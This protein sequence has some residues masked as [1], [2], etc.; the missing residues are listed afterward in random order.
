VV[1]SSSELAKQ[2]LK[3][4]DQQL[5]NRRRSRAALKFSRN[6]KDLIWADYGPNYVKVRKVSTLELLSSKKLKA[7]RPIREDE[8]TAMVESIFR[9]CTNPD[10]L[11]NQ[12]LTN[13]YDLKKKG[14]N[15]KLKDY[16]STVSFNNITRLV[17]G[18]RLMSPEGVL[19]EQGLEFKD[20]LG[21]G[22][23][24]WALVT[25]AEYIPWL[26]WMFPLEEEKYVKHNER[27]DKLTKTIMAEH[28]LARQKAGGAAKPHFVDVLLSLQEEYDL[29]DDTIIGLLWVGH[30]DVS[31]IYLCMLFT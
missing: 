3:E 4:N 29:N 30:C 14:Q 7:L 20:I 12:M 31:L 26:R 8:V 15:M 16:L 23:K 24:L 21:N 9:D 27:R 17:L 13:T 25:L 18:T 28:T 1:I 2:V 10:Q 6:G 19:N 11:I 5:S 22:V